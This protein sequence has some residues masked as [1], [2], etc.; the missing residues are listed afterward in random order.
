MLSADDAEQNARFAKEHAGDAFV[1]LSDPEKSTIESYGASFGPGFAKRWTFYIDKQGNIA[2]IDTSV[3]P[4]TAADEMI[5]TLK[6]L[7]LPVA[8]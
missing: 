1:I 2:K 8:E 5:D 7:G 6:E 4:V 3:K